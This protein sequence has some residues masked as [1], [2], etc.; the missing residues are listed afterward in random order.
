MLYSWWL[1]RLERLI[2]ARRASFIKTVTQHLYKGS[3]FYTFVRESNLS[4]PAKRRHPSSMAPFWKSSILVNWKCFVPGVLISHSLSVTVRNA[5]CSFT[6][7]SVICCFYI[8]ICSTAAW[9]NRRKAKAMRSVINIKCR[10]SIFLRKCCDE[11]KIILA[12]LKCTFFYYSCHKYLYHL[13]THSNSLSHKSFTILWW[14]KY[15]P[16]YTKHVSP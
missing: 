15:F 8:W 6:C 7:C 2:S 12:S 11:W 14:M 1:M 13:I 16:R 4:S 5:S 3:R 10:K 9:W